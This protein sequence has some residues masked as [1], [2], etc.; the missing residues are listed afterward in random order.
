MDNFMNKGINVLS[1]FDGISCGQIALE[2]AKIKTNKYYASEID[3]Y[4]IKVTQHNYPNTIQLGDVNKWRAWNIDWESIDLL[5]AGFPCQAWSFAGK[6]Q[7]MNDPRGAL[8]ITLFELFVFLKEK[9]PKLKFLFENVKMKKEY[10]IYL[11]NL[12]G[13]EPYNIDSCLVSAQKR[14]RMYWTNIENVNKPYDKNI[15]IADILESNGEF[16][17]VH[18]DRY[19][20]GK[21]RGISWQYDGSGKGHNSQNY[22]A[23][24]LDSKMGCLSHS[25]PHGAKI[26]TK[27]GVRKTTRN[28]HER[29]QTLPDNYTIPLEINK[30]KSAIG[31]GW[32]VD[33]IV[34]IFSFLPQE[35]KNG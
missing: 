5:C 16:E 24:F 28:E 1:L 10:L 18:A 33:V 20:S 21:K 2:R 7:G 8:A 29:L 25:A 32:T 15:K 23:Y 27:D 30:A 12:F 6:Q 17:F 31:N 22:R 34:H 9:N 13:V 4:A 11:N 14:D 3:K 19:Q 26:L 35:F